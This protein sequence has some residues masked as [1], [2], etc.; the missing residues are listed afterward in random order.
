M[1]IR[2]DIVT[3]IDWR[4]VNEQVQRTQRR[5]DAAWWRRLARSYERRT[6]RVRHRAGFAMG[7][8][9]A[10]NWFRLR[11]LRAAFGIGNYWWMEVNRES[12][13][14]YDLRATAC[15]FVAAMVAAGDA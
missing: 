15:S 2:T 6:R 14:A 13:E 11:Q 7:I 9:A 1:T 3:N 10:T 4:L 12:P 5:V 8:C